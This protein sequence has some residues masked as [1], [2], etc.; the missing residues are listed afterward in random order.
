MGLVILLPIRPP[1]TL[2][3]AARGGPTTRPHAS[4]YAPVHVINAN[5]RD[6]DC[7]RHCPSCLQGSDI[8]AHR[9]TAQSL[10]SEA[11]ISSIDPPPI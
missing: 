10:T 7:E 11:R 6:Y 5:S 1:P 8:R 9:R 3:S 4:T 2:D